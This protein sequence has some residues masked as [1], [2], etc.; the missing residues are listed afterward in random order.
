MNVIVLRLWIWIIISKESKAYYP[1]ELEKPSG[2][3][4]LLYNKMSSLKPFFH[5]KSFS[6]LLSKNPHSPLVLSKS[7]IVGYIS[8]SMNQNRGL[9]DHWEES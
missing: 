6:V 8:T 2:W 5:V 3:I 4:F 1:Q 9:A 7:A